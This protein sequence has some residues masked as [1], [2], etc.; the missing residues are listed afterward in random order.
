MFSVNQ[1]ILVQTTQKKFPW[2]QDHSPTSEIDVKSGIVSHVK[3]PVATFV[4]I[5]DNDS[6]S[7]HEY[8]SCEDRNT[9]NVS[10][11]LFSIPFI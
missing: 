2:S 6:S 11:K 9:G 1:N 8:D 10:A 4:T 5:R 3:M 7:E